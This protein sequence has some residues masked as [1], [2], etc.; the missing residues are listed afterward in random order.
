[1]PSPVIHKTGFGLIPSIGLHHIFLVSIS[2]SISDHVCPSDSLSV[3]N[4]FVNW[5]H[6]HQTI[7]SCVFQRLIRNVVVDVHEKICFF[8][9]RGSFIFVILCH[10]LTENEQA[11]KTQQ[12]GSFLFPHSFLCF[13]EYFL[14]VAPKLNWGDYKKIFWEGSNANQLNV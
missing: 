7:Y 1:M 2:D 5:L 6:M 9:L 11:L 12:P 10:T 13:E 8:G 4:Q 3:G 14:M